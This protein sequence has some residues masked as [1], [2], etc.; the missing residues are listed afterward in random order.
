MPKLLIN[1]RQIGSAVILDMSGD[2]IFGEGSK[3]LRSAIRQKIS[4]G[5]TNIFL[6]F[7]DVC[8]VD[9]SG[10][11]ELVSGYTALKREG[12][13]LTLLNLSP[14]VKELLEITKLLAVFEIY[15]EEFSALA[16]HN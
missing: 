12:G 11:G 4:E 1:E 8:Y 10:I 14:R 16:S 15:D 2:V 9:S 6:N 5:K 13:K 7:K 3:T